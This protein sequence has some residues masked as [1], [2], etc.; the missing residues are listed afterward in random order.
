[1]ARNSLFTKASIVDSLKKSHPELGDNLLEKVVDIFF[2]EIVTA[3]VCGDRVELRKFGSWVVRKREGKT[4]RNPRTNAKIVV[5]D[6]GSLYFRASRD[7]IKSLNSI[8]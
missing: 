8:K 2:N 1:M 6:K 3:L 4:V 7:L 5:G